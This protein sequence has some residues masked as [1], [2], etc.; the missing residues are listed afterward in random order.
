LSLTWEGCR[1]PTLATRN[2]PKHRADSSTGFY[3]FLRSL[4]SN[5]ETRVLYDAKIKKDEMENGLLDRTEDLEVAV[6]ALQREVVERERAEEALRESEGRLRVLFESVHDYAIFSLDR[7]GIVTSWNEGARR[8][9]G[10]TAEEIIGQPVTCFY[11]QEDVA[12]DKPGREMATALAVGR[13]EDE[14]WRVRKDGSR[15]W[16]NEIMT[17]LLA[18]DGRHLGFT[19]I[20]R[21]L[22]ERKRLEDELRG[23]RDEL[24]R[25]VLERTRELTEANTLLEKEV[26]QRQVAEG[27]VKDLL[28]KLVT[29]QEAE[30][31][32]LARELHDTLGQQLAAL[33]LGIALL[34]PK[35]DD[36]GRLQAQV[37]RLQKIF[38]QLDANIDFFAWELRPAALD[39]LGLDIALQSFVR[40]WSKQF[41]VET[42]YQGLDQDGERLPL[43]V[44]T[45]LYR[46][47]QEALQ[48]VYK[49][50]EADRVRLLLERHDGVVLLII[51]DNGKGYDVE[52]EESA[53]IPKGMGMIN[54]RERAALFAGS[55]EVESTPGAGTTVFVR[56][57][58]YSDA[59]RSE[60]K[61][62]PLSDSGS[63]KG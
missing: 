29:A 17:P 16:V 5:A 18:D 24:E 7:A 60:A 37:D 56:I 42:E 48:N 45:N 13:S 8:L 22:T 49:H 59:L 23:A 3:V 41:G 1:R 43:E 53:E 27:R 35:A 11:T 2:V 47:V 46:I 14:S 21:D 58:V 33:R 15:F 19:K 26:R 31:K 61:S 36:V 54:M 40:E 38:D 44:E 52:A 4:E 55:F 30:R 6:A 39:E 28:R 10:Y 9:K 32:R 25:R 50:A 12:A 34:K 20:S 63:D 51:E 57:P 62:D